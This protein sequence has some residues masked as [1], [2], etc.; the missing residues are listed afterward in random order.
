MVLVHS[1][2]THSQA[3]KQNRENRIKNA[4]LSNSHSNIAP[5][6]NKRLLFVQ[7]L[8]TSSALLVST[9]L[10]V[11]CLRPS[12]FFF[13]RG[14]FP[15]SF[16]CH[17][18]LMTHKL[19]YLSCDRILMTHELFYLSHDQILMTHELFYLSHDRILIIMG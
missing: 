19:F 12:N 5:S 3:E 11:Q 9:S 2:F 7:I 10:P 16:L 4:C 1:A 14:I 13:Y 18:I 6:N 8:A 15:N 17:R